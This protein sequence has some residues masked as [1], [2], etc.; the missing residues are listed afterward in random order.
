MLDIRIRK[1]ENQ[2][3]GTFR[4]VRGGLLRGCSSDFIKKKK[5]SSNI[6]GKAPERARGTLLPPVD[7]RSISFDG[8]V[9]AL[10]ASEQEY[11]N[12]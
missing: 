5:I 10:E 7:G 4:S 12:K 2:V 9:G 8:S 1:Y 3:N 11:Q 6:P